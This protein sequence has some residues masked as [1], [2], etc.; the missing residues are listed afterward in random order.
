MNNEVSGDTNK[1]SK[2]LYKILIG[3]ICLILIAYV[4]KYVL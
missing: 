4:F 2:I 1:L 3:V